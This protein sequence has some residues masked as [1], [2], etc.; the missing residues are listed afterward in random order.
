MHNR[1][2]K[3]HSAHFSVFVLLMHN[4]TTSPITSSLNNDN[5]NN[6]TAQ[7]KGA[8]SLLSFYQN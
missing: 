4:C 3:L 2:Y 6:E 8:N 5:T 7:F 1:Q